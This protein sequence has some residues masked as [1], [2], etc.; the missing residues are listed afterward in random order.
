M[1][2]RQ[3]L[4]DLIKDFKTAMLVTRERDGGL[5]ARPMAVAEMK[6]DADA[7]FSTS[8]ESPK[9]AEIEADPRVLITFLGRSEFAS[10]VGTAT[11]VRDR[12][13]IDRLWAEDWRLWFPEGKDDPTLC[14]LKVSA[15]RAE[16]WDTSGAEG[17]RF[18]FEGLKA[19]I[20]GRQPRKDAAQNAKVAL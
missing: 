4:Y 5:H 18:L 15:K 14:L 11:V 19:L 1:D 12:A 9:I 17:V 2:T 6:P 7:Y 3:H 10:I 8:I 16:Y 20:Q 13:L